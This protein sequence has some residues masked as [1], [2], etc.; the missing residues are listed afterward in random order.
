M[1]FMKAVFNLCWYA[2][3]QIFKKTVH[4]TLLKNILHLSFDKRKTNMK[5]TLSDTSLKGET[6]VIEVVCD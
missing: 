4:C 2:D 5:I 6:K 1:Q 3:F